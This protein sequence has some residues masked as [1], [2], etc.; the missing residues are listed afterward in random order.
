MEGDPQKRPREGSAPCAV[1]VDLCSDSEGYIDS[2]DIEDSS[3]HL[4]DED[5]WCYEVLRKTF[6]PEALEK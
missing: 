1:V 3:E 2:S 4:Y 5:E 6:T